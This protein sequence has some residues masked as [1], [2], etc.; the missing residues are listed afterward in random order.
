MT[1]GSLTRFLIGAIAVILYLLL[2]VGTFFFQN[3]KE[4]LTPS[5]PEKTSIIVGCVCQDDTHS[6]ELGGEGAWGFAAETVQLRELETGTL[7]QQTRTRAGGAFFF[8]V[9][10]GSYS[11]VLLPSTDLLATRPARVVVLVA[12]NEVESVYFGVT[13]F[14][15]R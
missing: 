2:V 6:A 3:G 13:I 1:T 9:A 15:G 11:V 10:P 4:I 5:I 12:E 8:Q 7:L 14:E